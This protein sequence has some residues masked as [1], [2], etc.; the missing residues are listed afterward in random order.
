M[1]RELTPPVPGQERAGIA[2]GQNTIHTLPHDTAAIRQ[3]LQHVF[4]RVD[5]TDEP[6]IHGVVLAVDAPAVMAIGRVAATMDR[7]AG[8]SVLAVP[9]AQRGARALRS[10]VP[11]VLI[12][13][14]GDLLA[15]M[16][17]SLAKLTD[18]RATVFA[19]ADDLLAFDEEPLAAIISELPRNAARI[20]VAAR[21]T[22]EVESFAERFVRRLPRGTPAPD[23][24]L[25]V[26]IGYVGVAEVAKPAALRRVLDLLDPPTAVVYSRTDEGVRAAR[27]ELEAMGSA[28]HGV[29][30]TTELT[31]ADAE[32]LVL[33]ELPAS[34]GDLRALAS[35]GVKRVVALARPREMPLLRALAGS[36][37]HPLALAGPTEQAR[38]R[39]EA[40]RDALRA[41]LAEGVPSRELLALEPLL[42]EYDGVEIAAA[43]LRLLERGRAG[44]PAPSASP[45]TSP[46]ASPSAEPA[47]A[48]VPSRGSVRVF[49]NVGTRDGA[50]ARDLVGAIVNVAGVPVD[51]IGKVE[52]RESHAL[53]EL[54]S[55]DADL[56]VEK[57][58]GATI[59][60]RRIAARADRDRAGADRG[61]EKPRERSE[62][63]GGGGARPRERSAER[64][65]ARGDR[66]TGRGSKRPASSERSGSWSS[67]RKGSRAS[68]RSSA[69]SSDRPSGRGGERTGA[70][71]SERPAGRGTERPGSRGSARPAG[72]GAE[73]SGSRSG[74]RSGPPARRDR[75]QAPR[76]RRPD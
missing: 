44:R 71:S 13:T 27:A 57:L 50:A 3:F 25:R 40:T 75:S 51:R 69:S 74:E 26:P 21:L 9:S 48:R 56:V 32:L 59:R 46:S 19:W 53:V 66:P 35:G 4:D 39:E 1:E 67:E 58:T 5:T 18:V 42:E 45:S 33:Y 72:R 64:T 30:V 17:E 36:H 38:A 28:G 37:A 15:L 76:G 16:R 60:G 6:A 73:R 29:R 2:R 22:S 63:F 8:A 54:Q 34:A 61:T 43:A 7:P 47:A 11:S 68:E 31:V 55:D 65:G 24:P 49:I 52:L 62:R 70:R 10:A 41:V 14:P 12:A 20:L 23:E